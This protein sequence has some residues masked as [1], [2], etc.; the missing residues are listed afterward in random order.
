LD[1]QLTIARGVALDS[2]GAIFVPLG[3]EC[4]DHRRLI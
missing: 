3:F 1:D 2:G 4:P